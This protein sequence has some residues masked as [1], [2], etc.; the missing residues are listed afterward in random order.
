MGWSSGSGLFSEVALLILNYVDDE[1]TR[2]T[3]YECMIEIFEQ[4]DCDT[5]QECV[6]I[7]DVLDEVLDD[8]FQ[9]RLEEDEIE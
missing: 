4:R 7:D 9:E 6:G 3:I 2:S 8:H 5:L 1:K